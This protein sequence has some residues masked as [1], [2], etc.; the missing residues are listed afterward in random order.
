M[1]ASEWSRK[2]PYQADLAA[3][4]RQA[5]DDAYREGDYYRVEPDPRARRIG[6]QEYIA[7]EVAAMRETW[8]EVFGEENA[9]DPDDEMARVAW[10]AAQIEVTGPD[11]LLASQPFSGTHSVIDMTGVADR[12]D[13][14]K[15]APLPA[16]EL[17]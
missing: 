8:V 16:D 12:P 17:D 2:V 9:G 13:G 7:A 3:A 14:G 11:S 1:G 6:E 15:V 5:R 10:R 4:L